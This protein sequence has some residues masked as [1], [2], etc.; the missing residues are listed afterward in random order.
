ML[1]YTSPSHTPN[2]KRREPTLRSIEEDC[3]E[4]KASLHYKMGARS[5]LRPFL[6]KLD[7]PTPHISKQNS[8]SRIN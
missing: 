6:R 1:T 3:C 7:P 8:V 2:K 5:R 4:L